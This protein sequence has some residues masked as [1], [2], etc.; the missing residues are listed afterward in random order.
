MLLYQAFYAV[1]VGSF[2]AL[3]QQGTPGACQV[4]DLA[5][6]SPMF[7]NGISIKV[8]GPTRRKGTDE[9]ITS[10]LFHMLQIVVKLE[11][12]RAILTGKGHLLENVH[13][14]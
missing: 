7:V 14:V 10:A 11:L 4:D 1:M 13:H 5:S 12:H 9:Q 8:L 2:R 3:D 6:C